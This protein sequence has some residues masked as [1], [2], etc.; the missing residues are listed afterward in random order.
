MQW[1]ALISTTLLVVLTVYHLWIMLT[2][3]A[4]A[5]I[6]EKRAKEIE[7]RANAADELVNQ[8][9]ILDR[10][11]TDIITRSL[12]DR[13][14]PYWKAWCQTMGVISISVEAERKFP[15]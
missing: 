5:A 10:A 1:I 7:E 9:Y 15:N 14:A 12:I 2:L 3:G 11:L 13:N 8:A 6:L 4:R